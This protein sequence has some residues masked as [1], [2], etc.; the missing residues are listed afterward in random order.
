[1]GSKLYASRRYPTNW[2]CKQEE[3]E[4]EKEGNLGR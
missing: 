1:M 2:Q 4:E 3:E